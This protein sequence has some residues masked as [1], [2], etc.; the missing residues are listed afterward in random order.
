[1]AFDL[2]VGI[3][4]NPELAGKVISGQWYT[5]PKLQ[6]SGM[7]VL[8]R[9]SFTCVA[10]GFV[11]RPSRQ[12]PHAHMIPVDPDSGRFVSLDGKGVCLCPLCASTT[13]INWSVVSRS[14]SGKE[15]PAP[16]M[17][18]YCPYLSQVELNRI[19]LHSVSI[20]ASRKVGAGSL[21][22][23]AIRD[24]DASM[25][26][27]NHELGANLPIY[28]GKDSEFARALAMLTQPLY[29]QRAELLGNVRW[30]P[31]L[32]FWAEQGLYWSKATYDLIHASRPDLMEAMV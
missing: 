22:D 32:N 1:M 20:A 2:N 7:S 24:L 6:A 23:S 5:N 4:E 10:C 16:G 29:E 15:M 21:L 27:L 31:T 19:A 30:W 11:T 17:L 3:A 14:L 18:I 25:V 8:K 9:H 28:R 12:V 13:A 26:G